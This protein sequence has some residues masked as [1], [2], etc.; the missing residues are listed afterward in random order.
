MSRDSLLLQL[1]PWLVMGL[2][3]YFG[4]IGGW[5]GLVSRI[6]PQL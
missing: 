6:L 5:M 3:L 4:Q 1:L 2:I